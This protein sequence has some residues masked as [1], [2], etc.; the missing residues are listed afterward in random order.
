MSAPA[1]PEA[2]LEAFQETH[3]TMLAEPDPDG[4]PLA[5]APAAT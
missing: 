2:I 1:D 4:E 5:E 3:E